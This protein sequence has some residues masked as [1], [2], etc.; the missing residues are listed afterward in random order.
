MAYRLATK[1]GLT[2]TVKRDEIQ[3]Q[4]QPASVGNQWI[5]LTGNYGYDKGLRSDAFTTII[6]QTYRISFDLGDYNQAGFGN[7]TLGLQIN[8][9]PET[10]F[11]NLLS[12]SAVMDWKAYSLDWIAN[13]TSTSLTFIGRKNGTS[14]ND[15]GI[16]LDNVNVDLKAQTVPTPSTLALMAVFLLGIFKF[17][18]KM[19]R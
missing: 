11:T 7:A 19:N 12:T 10:L 1:G 18:L 17:R 8:S 14:S 15:A 13:A 4:G 16:G 2:V 5:D 6:G 3:G 9:N